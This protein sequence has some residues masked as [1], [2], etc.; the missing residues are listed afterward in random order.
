MQ[1]EEA[2]SR[3]IAALKIFN[4]LELAM[5]ASLMSPWARLVGAR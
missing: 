5:K 4:L 3:S 2:G 1:V